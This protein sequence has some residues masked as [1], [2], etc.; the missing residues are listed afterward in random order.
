MHNL[1]D[2]CELAFNVG[3]LVGVDT[4]ILVEDL[5]D[6]ADKSAVMAFLRE[7][8]SVL[9]MPEP[10]EVPLEAVTEFQ[11]NWFR[12][13]GYFAKEVAHIV[14]AEEDLEASRVQEE[15][16]VREEQVKQNKD[17]LYTTLF[18]F[19]GV[20]KTAYAKLLICILLSSEI[21]Q[22]RVLKPV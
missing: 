4:S 5:T 6:H 10:V 2:N 8:R 15:K 22:C 14:Q 12:K 11:L 13:C 7:L 19:I 9:S 21:P 3:Q 18:N 17:K 16:E 20:F 1:K